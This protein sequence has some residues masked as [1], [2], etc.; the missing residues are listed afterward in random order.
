MY[1]IYIYIGFA[2]CKLNAPGGARNE[3]GG[4]L[5]SIPSVP[6]RFLFGYAGLFEKYVSNVSRHD[7]HETSAQSLARMPDITRSP[8]LRIP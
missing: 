3:R 1:I 6:L 8:D 7:G 2:K 5:F 4:A